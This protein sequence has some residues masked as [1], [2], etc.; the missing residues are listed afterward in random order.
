MW[1]RDELKEIR[2]RA[3]LE[4]K[5]PGINPAWQHACLTLAA[6]ADRVD[7]M[8]ARIEIGEETAVA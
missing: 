2:S 8:T 1:A 3:E 5:V 4:A 7:A 6:A